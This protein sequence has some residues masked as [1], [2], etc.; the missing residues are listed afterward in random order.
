MALNMVQEVAA[1]RQM[2][3]QELRDKWR[4]AFGEE[5]RSSHRE[6]LIK[7]IAWRLQAL[8]EGDLSERARR[9]AEQLAHDADLRVTAPRERRPVQRPSAPAHPIAVRPPADRRLPMPGTVVVR[10]YKGQRLHVT[11]LRAGFAYEGEIYASLSAVPRKITGQH[12][13]GYL[14]FGL[15]KNG[16]RG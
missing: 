14:F 5:T 6:Y 12:W 13:N 7:R 9:R 16:G 8:E 3:T 11:V 15:A 1:M 4:E 10:E 2:S